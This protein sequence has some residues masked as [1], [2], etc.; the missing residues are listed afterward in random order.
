MTDQRTRYGRFLHRATG[1]PAG[2]LHPP[3][4]WAPS[5]EFGR[6]VESLPSGGGRPLAESTQ[7][8][9]SLDP[10]AATLPE[11]TG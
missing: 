5:G 1:E 10:A 7:V 3:R 9:S 6:P 11:S 8:G 2:T 4:Q